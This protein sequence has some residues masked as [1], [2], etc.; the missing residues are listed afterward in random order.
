MAGSS[1]GFMI[2]SKQKI[3]LDPERII[4]QWLILS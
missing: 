4:S 2:K 1:L 3:Q